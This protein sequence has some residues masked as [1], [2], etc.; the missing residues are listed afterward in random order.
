VEIFIRVIK[1]ILKMGFV[2][3]I[4]ILVIPKAQA[5]KLI[6][7]CVM[8]ED[9]LDV[10]GQNI[11]QL[12]PIASVSKI[13]T[14]LMA[15]TGFN[16]D[17][18]FYTQIYVT[19]TS[20][21]LFDVHIKGTADP[22]FNKFKMHMIISK[23]NE[24]NVTRVRN[25]TFDENVKYLHETDS[26]RGFRVGNKLIQP[27]VLKADLSY[28]SPEIVKSELSQMSIILKSY[29]DSL[30]LAKSNG[31]D[32]FKNPTFTVQK[33]SF[34]S[35]TEYKPTFNVQKIFVSSQN[36][37]T[38]LKSLNW[39]SN[40]H[41][42]NQ[43]FVAAGGLPRF[44]KLFYSDFKESENDVSFVNGSGQ[45]HDLSGEGR[46]YNQATCQNVLRTLHMLNRATQSQKLQ[47]QDIMSVVGLDRLS[48]VGGT[49]YSNSLTTGAVVAKTG[50]VG[51]N[52]ALAGIAN[53]KK[54]QKYFMYNVQ[55]RSASSKKESRTARQM[56][57]AQ[58]QKLIKDNGGP[59]KI[60]YTSQNPLNDNLE[61]YD[62]DAPDQN[63]ANSIKNIAPA[64]IAQGVQK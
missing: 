17:Y 46:I 54:G 48:T 38:I 32:L 42:A 51:T 52:I 45:N 43:M 50:T 58:L 27:L 11:D 33:T 23:L 41:A 35:S 44:R 39:N 20:T 34:L 19:P 14:T 7:S 24:M 28:P 61:N 64:T 29:K 2:F 63:E 8:S 55:L 26:L 10:S 36:I 22:Y 13:Y 62:E 5:A 4:A 30:K 53:T 37:R 31:I 56:I 15:V 60:K 1:T 9:R 18:K 3:T 12:M 59:M 16:L 40:N 47:L 6:S 49:T 25:L 57:S 21:N